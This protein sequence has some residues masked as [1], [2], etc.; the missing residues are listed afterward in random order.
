MKRAADGPAEGAVAAPARV[1]A[2]PRPHLDGA[3]RALAAASGPGDEAAGGAEVAERVEECRAAAQD[4]EAGK[5]QAA[6]LAVERRTE[7]LAAKKAA[8]TEAKQAKMLEIQ[9]RYQA[10]LAC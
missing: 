8:A 10:S 7:V 4:A 9:E 3:D 5:R 6:A 1:P 2:V